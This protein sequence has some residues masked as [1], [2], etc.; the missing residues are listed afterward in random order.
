ML[1]KMFDR[2]RFSRPGEINVVKERTIEVRDLKF[3]KRQEESL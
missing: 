2:I 1:Y 3:C